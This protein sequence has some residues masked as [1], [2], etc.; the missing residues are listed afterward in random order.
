VNDFRVS[1]DSELDWLAFQ[2]VSGEL[3]TVEEA[4]FEARL[5]DDQSAR[6]AVAR[7]AELV[8]ALAVS[9][10]PSVLQ[11]HSAGVNV[12]WRKLAGAACVAALLLLAVSLRML[13]VPADRSSGSQPADGVPSSEWMPLWSQAGDFDLD[14]LDF[15][16]L[17]RPQVA[18]DGA[19]DELVVPSW[20]VAALEHDHDDLMEEDR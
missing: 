17:Q 14:D 5:A 6:E 20:M 9:R 18:L 2:Y 19:A 11:P 3:A 1:T 15:N 4:A 16:E 10:P 8:G 7:A 12:R 13:Q